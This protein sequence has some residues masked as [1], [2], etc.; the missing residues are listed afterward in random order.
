MK[1]GILALL[2]LA[3]VACDDSNGVTEPLGG[4]PVDAGPG[5]TPLDAGLDDAGKPKDC[6]DPP[7]TTHFQ[8]IN[9]CTNADKIDRKPTS[10]KIFPDGGVPKP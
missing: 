10:S 7:F 9:A 3:L 6:F 1:T 2:A 8:I 5:P 4:N